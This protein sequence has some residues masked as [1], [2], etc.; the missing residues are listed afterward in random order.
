MPEGAFEE[1][2]REREARAEMRAI[3]ARG[4]KLP[5]EVFSSMMRCV[6][7]VQFDS[8]KPIESYDHRGHTYAA[9]AQGRTW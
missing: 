6:C 4:E 3:Q 7:G 1:S 5:S 8:W 9:Q 2:R